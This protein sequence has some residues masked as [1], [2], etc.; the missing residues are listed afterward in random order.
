VTVNIGFNTVEWAEAID[1]IVRLLPVIIP[2]VI[3]Q[4]VLMITAIVSL[5]RKPNPMNEK[6]LWLLLILI[7]NT[8][9]PVVYFAAGIN[10]LDQK[11]A[12]RE[13]MQDG[14]R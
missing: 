1:L 8:I 14:Q 7:V 5:V 10:Y 6:I 2:I 4:M 11:H 3:I 12:E 9:G 13:D